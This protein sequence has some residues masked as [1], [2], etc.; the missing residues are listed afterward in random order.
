MLWQRY[1][2]QR[3]I[4]VEM[5]RSLSQELHFL[6]GGKVGVIL[7][8]EAPRISEYCSFS[9]LD[10]LEKFALAHMEEPREL[11]EELA[12]MLELAAAHEMLKTKA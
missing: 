6:D 1:S 8:H 12:L 4:G 10:D 2:K 3:S 5:A 7:N 11:I 9:D